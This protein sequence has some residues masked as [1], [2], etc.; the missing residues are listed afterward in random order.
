MSHTYEYPR[1]ALTVDSVIFGLADG[2]NDL[3]IL[4]IQRGLPPY[5]GC[6]ALPGGF[7]DMAEDLDAA[8]RRELR[9]ETGAEVDYLEQ[10][11]TFGKPG[12]DPRDRT[13]SV[14]YYGLVRSRD[15]L[16]AGASDA[17]RAVWVSHR[18]AKDLAFDHDTIVQMALKRLRAKITYDHDGDAMFEDA[19][20]TSGTATRIRPSSR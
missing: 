2:S 6:W 10:L 19:A 14:A 7:V 17:R 16:V 9:E 13:I 5:E 18:Q 12:R 15:H 11:Y 3:Q 4:L 8:A 1:P 20:N